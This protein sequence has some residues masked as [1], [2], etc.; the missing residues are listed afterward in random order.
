[1]NKLKSNRIDWMITLAPFILIMALAGV[2]FIFPEQSN[3][4]I[5]QI[6]NITVNILVR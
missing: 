5:G 3:D 4:I 1:M 2:L 6:M